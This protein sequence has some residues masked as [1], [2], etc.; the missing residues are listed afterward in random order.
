MST[1]NSHIMSLQDNGYGPH[2]Y[3]GTY[4]CSEFPA[5]NAPVDFYVSFLTPLL[6]DD[7]MIAMF[8]EKD[9]KTVQSQMVEYFGEYVKFIMG[10][11]EP[12]NEMTG[13]KLYEPYTLAM[14]EEDSVA[15]KW[16]SAKMVVNENGIKTSNGWSNVTQ[17]SIKLSAN[18][19]IGIKTHCSNIREYTNCAVYDFKKRVII[20]SLMSR[21]CRKVQFAHTMLR[22]IWSDGYQ[23]PPMAMAI[24]DVADKNNLDLTHLDCLWAAYKIRFGINGNYNNYGDIFRRDNGYLTQECF[25][26]RFKDEKFNTSVM[27]NFKEEVDSIISNMNIS[28]TQ[29]LDYDFMLKALKKEASSKPISVTNI[30]QIKKNIDKDIVQNIY[31]YIKKC[32]EDLSLKAEIINFVFTKPLFRSAPVNVKY[33]GVM[34]PNSKLKRLLFRD[35]EECV[36]SVL[37]E[38]QF[39]SLV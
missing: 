4:G 25:Q 35:D 15:N 24:K 32:R 37:S 30:N 34:K 27:E 22:L 28:T 11:L 31:D 29:R 18:D 19:V 17:F 33:V 16:E 9:G 2:L 13:K 6:S 3:I 5:L 12:L 26:N 10:I 14:Y 21:V 23:I 1:S 36:L 38:S 8:K 20:R 39:I 7:Q